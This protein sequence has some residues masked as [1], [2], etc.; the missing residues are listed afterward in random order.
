MKRERRDPEGKES[1]ARGAYRF[2]VHRRRIIAGAAAS[3]NDA[4]GLRIFAEEPLWHCIERIQ[5][6]WGFKPVFRVR[7]Y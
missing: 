6:R 1:R 4:N 5:T 3:R 2:D 7:F